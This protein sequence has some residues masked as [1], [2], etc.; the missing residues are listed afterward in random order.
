MNEIKL[1][2]WGYV[3]VWEFRPQKGA[4]AKFED[5]YGPHGVWAKLFAQGEGFVATEL[6]RDLKDS[7]RYFTMDF[8]V[9]KD[10]FEAFRAAHQEEYQA[11][12]QQC[13]ALT[14]EEKMVGA[15]E[16]LG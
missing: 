9:S 13:E 11:I 8:W 4:E 2:R 7:S 14:A 5:A 1:A 12:D 6:N 15:F 10:A 3:A 16:R